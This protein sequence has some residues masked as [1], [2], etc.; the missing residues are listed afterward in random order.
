MIKFRFA[1]RFSVSLMLAFGPIG[2]LSACATYQS[3]VKD[4]REAMT[5]GD[6]ARAAKLLQPKA[7]KDNDDQLVYMLDYAT[8]LQDGKQ[9]KESAAAFQ[10]ADKIAD[11]QDYHSISKITAS[12]LVSEGM[13]QY[14]GDDY[15]KVLIHAMDSLNYLEMNEL[16]DALVE[17]RKLNEMLYKFKNEAKKDYDQNPFAFYLGGAIY[18]ADHKWDDA[19]ISYKSAYAVE[20]GFS[21]LREDLVRLAIRADRQDDLEKWKKEFPE[22]KVKPEWKD[23]SMGQI[24]LVYAQGWGPRKMPRPG[25]PRFPKLFPVYTSTQRARLIVDDN[26]PS[27]DTKQVFSVERVAIKTLEDD[28]ARLVGMRVGGVVAKAVVSEEIARK[29]PL[30]GELAFIG[31]N[32][33]D[34]ADLRQWSTLPQTFQIARVW[35]PSGKHKIQIRGVAGSGAYTMESAQDREVVVNPGQ[36]VFVTWRSVR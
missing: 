12:L 33:A 11:I 9:Y 15:E 28:Y 16:D 14:K 19:Y 23:S 2:L 30:L 27:M 8:A 21:P 6:N 5:A 4:A 25:A 10:K 3:D 18:E 22:V 26:G 29:N 35:V 34:K 24:I 1:L 32:A 36:T 13:V 20:P 17:T 31:L 7:E